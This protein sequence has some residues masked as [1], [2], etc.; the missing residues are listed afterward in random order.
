MKIDEIIAKA[1]EEDINEGDHTSLAI[2]DPNANGKAKLIIKEKGI[3]AGV[4]IAK[5]TFKHVNKNTKFEILINDGT[6]VKEGDIAFYVEGKIISILGAERVALNFMQR[7]S[8]IATHT[9]KIVQ[10]LEGLNTKLLDTRK[11][12]P[13]L[14]IL[15]K[16]AVKIGG[17]ENHRFG[18]FDMIMIKDNHI[19]FAGGIEQAIRS[20]NEYLKKTK[21]KLKIEIE[22]RTVFE[23]IKVMEL[24]GVDRVMFD[25]FR[26]TDIKS[27]MKI[28]NKKFETEAS[29]NIT[30]K[31]IRKY[32]STGVDYI[33]VGSLTNNVKG[34]D[35]SLL[36]SE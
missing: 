25:N 35:M 31:N 7:M 22:V 10:K 30:I 13:N 27:A 24:G 4:E 12:A 14:R 33:S 5:K 8:G 2:I 28:M 17:G 20:A 34:M 16:M 36:A 19:D 32:A 18:L 29:G 21:K 26:F 23:L 15:D 3:L 6:E 11:T 1:I 9:N